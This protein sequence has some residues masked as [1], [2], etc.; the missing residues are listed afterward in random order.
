MKKVMKKKKVNKQFI[1]VFTG[2]SLVVLVFILIA[3]HIMIPKLKL[4][5]SNIDV[6]VF[7]DFN[8]IG[9][10]AQSFGKDIK[11]DVEIE[12]NVDTNKIGTYK[13]TYKVKNNFFTV[14]KTLNVNVV[15]KVAPELELIGN[16]EYNV[17]SID[18]FIEP[19][20]TSL[21]NYDGDI[22]SNVIVNRNNELIEYKSVDS[23]KNESIK[24]RKL[25]IEDNMSPEIKLNGNGTT[26]VVKGSEFKDPGATAKD[27]CDG[28][29]TNAI[30]VSGNVDSNKEGTYE[31]TYKVKDGNNNEST[32][33]RK[34]IVS[35]KNQ[36][37]NSGQGGIV[38]LTFDDGPGSYTSSILDTLKKYDVKATFFVTMSGSDD[39]LRREA[40]EGHT[41]A[42]HTATHNYKT[43]YA[44]VDAY[45]NDLNQV[46]NR[47]K[48]VTG[49][50]TKYVRFPGGSSNRVSKVCMSVLTRE[51][52]NKGYRYYDWNGD[53]NDAGSCAGARDK[54]NCVLN[55]FKKYLLS[56]R[57]NVMLM[58]DIK[59]YTA[60][61]LPQMIEYA[62]SRGFT[63][64][65]ID[66]SAPTAHHGTKC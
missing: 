5:K 11:D 47:I 25:I 1:Y 21:D 16:E 23:S 45:F 48:N 55:N 27:N 7:D 2:I 65:A 61:A 43:I 51:L 57:G 18:S 28:D 26:Y 40:E 66:D 46:A 20:Y 60:Q 29:L 17:C 9:Y 22:T 59:S 33:T 53:V 19:G 63:F 52:S 49:K 64:K 8:G 58:H 4:E 35:T 62:K 13:V 54:V 32:I 15:D 30:E 34:V 10:T 24:Q 31:L 14:K 6:N 3:I 42:I 56:N 12:G 39:V 37:S 36:S 38:Y 41:V 50:E 44:S